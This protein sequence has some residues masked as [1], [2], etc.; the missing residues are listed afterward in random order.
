MRE[1]RVKYVRNSRSVICVGGKRDRKK[2]KVMNIK[3]VKT[4]AEDSK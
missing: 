2:L 3:W 4:V 1:E